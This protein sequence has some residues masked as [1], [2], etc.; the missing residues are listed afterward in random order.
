MLLL[1]AELKGTYYKKATNME[2]GDLTTY[3]ARANAFAIG[4]I[5]GEPTADVTIKVA[6]AMAFEIFAQGETAQVEEIT[7]N[8]TEA[9]PTG[10]YSRKAKN[11]PLDIVREMLG[12]ARKAFEA[13]STATAGRGVQFL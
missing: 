7:G 6:V 13:A 5:G 2:A 3:L 4:V 10:Y 8:I 9:A 1:E 12:P 11:D